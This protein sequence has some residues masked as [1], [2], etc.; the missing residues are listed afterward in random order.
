MN[1]KK[2]PSKKQCLHILI[3]GGDC[4]SQKFISEYLTKKYPEFALLT[5]SVNDVIDFIK[6]CMDGEHDIVFLDV[7]APEMDGLRV[8]SVVK[9]RKPHLYIVAVVAAIGDLPKKYQQFGIEDLVTKPICE[10][11]LSLVI[12]EAIKRK[13]QKV[14]V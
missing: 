8:S 4:G 2:M 7:L 5:T 11:K 12:E 14:E 6:C 10:E 3:A 9:G 13:K 1:S